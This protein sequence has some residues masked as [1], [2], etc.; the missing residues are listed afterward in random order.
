[1]VLA[2]T[3]ADKGDFV[4]KFLSLLKQHKLNIGGPA[5]ISKSE[6]DRHVFV[7]RPGNVP[8]GETNE[9]LINEFLENVDFNTHDINPNI[10]F[11]GGNYFVTLI[12][13]RPRPVSGPKRD[14]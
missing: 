13:K 2:I 8:E 1:M 6:G 5:V 14:S 3:E 4:R 12:P 10:E 9:S 7:F 11:R